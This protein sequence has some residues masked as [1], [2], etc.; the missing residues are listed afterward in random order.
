MIVGSA[1][2]LAQKGPIQP[3]KE[4]ALKISDLGNFT[5]S[6]QNRRDPFE[7]IYL[8]KVKETR[9]KVGIAKSGYEL[10]ELK[11]VGIVRADKAKYAMM[12]DIQGKGIL[13]KKGD[14]L[15]SNVWVEEIQE[16]SIALGYKTKRGTRTIVMEI[17]K[18]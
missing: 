14:F 15:N 8:Q 1:Q 4:E 16:G 11:L 3:K 7:P 17:P 5:Y 2:V 12:E 18:K 9:D 13:F 6:S 10:E